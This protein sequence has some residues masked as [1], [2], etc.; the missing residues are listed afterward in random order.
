MRR[1]LGSGSFQTQFAF[2][3]GCKTKQNSYEFGIIVYLEIVKY[4]MSCR[5]PRQCCEVENQ[6]KS[7][8]GKSYLCNNH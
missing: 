4:R 3:D 5:P 1:Q 6:A 7:Y 2:L 8:R